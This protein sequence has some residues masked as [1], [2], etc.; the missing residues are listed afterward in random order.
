MRSGVE[1]L[2]T[3]VLDVCLGMCVGQWRNVVFV[4]FCFLVVVVVLGGGL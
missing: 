4:C 2:M 1:L 3:E